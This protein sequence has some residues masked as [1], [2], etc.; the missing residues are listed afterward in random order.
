MQQETTIQFGRLP[1]TK[2]ERKR[3]EKKLIKIYEICKLF[4]TKTPLETH[5]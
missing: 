2:F 5:Q 1:N 3:E 4:L